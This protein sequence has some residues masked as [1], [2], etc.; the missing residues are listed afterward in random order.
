MNKRIDNLGLDRGGDGEITE[1]IFLGKVDEEKNVEELNISLV[2]KIFKEG[3]PAAYSSFLN[4]IQKGVRLM[5]YFKDPKNEK[6]IDEVRE[7][8]KINLKELERSIEENYKYIPEIILGFDKEIEA[9]KKSQKWPD[10]TNPDPMFARDLRVIIHKKIGLKSSDLKYYTGVKSSIDQKCVDAMFEFNLQN[11]KKLMLFFDLTINTESG[12]QE[13]K[14]RRKNR[15]LQDKE[16]FILYIQEYFKDINKKIYIERQL[17]GLSLDD[18]N[19][20]QKEVK[21]EVDKKYQEVMNIIS[22]IVIKEFYI[23]LEKQI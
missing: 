20:R 10:P 16:D 18:L 21:E 3:S 22:D 15:K 1:S 12:K 4:Q 6:D 11:E 8:M 5:E 2:K 19:P 7:K 14:S 13:Q 17:Q 23:K 9:T